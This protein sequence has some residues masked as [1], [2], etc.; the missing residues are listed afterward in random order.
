MN[1]LYANAKNMFLTSTLDWVASNVKVALVDKS[2]Y[3]AD[4]TNDQYLSDVPTEAITKLSGN[5]TTKTAVKG[6]ADADNVVI[7]AVTGQV[8]AIVLFKD[9]GTSSTS[10][11]IAYIDTSMGLPILMNSGDF[12]IQWNDGSSKIFSL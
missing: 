11:L 3:N 9:T 6:V 1:A 12:S 8:D 10:P 2:K 5:L 4:V 7:P